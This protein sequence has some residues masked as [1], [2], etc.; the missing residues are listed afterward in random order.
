MFRLAVEVRRGGGGV[1]GVRG[2]TRT[3]R[4]DVVGADVDEEDAA[5]G[6][7]LRQSAGG[8]D[9]DGESGLG[10]GG[11]DVG[12]AFGGAVD[13]C[14]GAAGGGSESGHAGKGEV[15]EGG[16]RGGVNEGDDGGGVSEIEFMDCGGFGAGEAGADDVPF[17]T[18][19]GF[20]ALAAELAGGAGDEDGFIGHGDVV[21]FGIGGNGEVGEL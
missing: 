15:C 18:L 17:G 14:A 11:A 7:S 3:T 16:L 4:E 9:V 6:A 8:G 2:F 12:G 13:N 5:V 10:G 1:G 20:E 19:E 21:W